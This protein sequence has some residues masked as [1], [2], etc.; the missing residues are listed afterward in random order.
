MCK[1]RSALPIIV[2]LIQTNPA[3]AQKG[4]VGRTF[5]PETKPVDNSEFGFEVTQW[6]QKGSNNHLYF[7]IESFIDA[8][9]FVF[10]SDRSGR[11]NLFKMS[12]LDGTITQMT[13][14][15]GMVQS[16]WHCPQ[17]STVWFV[18]KNELKAV[19]TITLKTCPVYAFEKG[20][21]ASFAVTCDGRYCVFTVNKNPGFSK[22]HSTGPNALFRLD[23]QTKEVRQ[24][25]PD[26][27]VF[28]GHVLANPVDPNIIL[29]VW[30][31][32]MGN[33]EPGIVGDIPAKLWWNNIDG[34]D[35]GQLGTQAFGLHITHPAWFPNGQQI[36]YSARYFFGPN[37]GK[38][39]VGIISSDGKDNLMVQANIGA[40]H[41]QMY[42]DSKHW[43]FDRYNGPYLVMFTMEGKKIAAAETLFRHDSSF[44]G[45]PSHPHPH[46][47]PDGKYVLFSTDRSGRPQVYTVKVNLGQ[48][49]RRA[50]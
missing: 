26:V 6:T 44:K 33:G 5:P 46:F 25:S 35:G 32:V 29:Y 47:S 10:F 9:H 1:L 22:N 3:T 14:E 12:L 11:T 43:V 20:P 15:E 18:A 36:S 8:D 19:N 42:S 39:F 38:Q 7:N 23:L 40:A 49:P 48:P 24:I 28:L 4:S 34:S 21:P 2:M 41:S 17:F 45:Q 16:V 31:P 37:K 27:G 50:Q 30:K 13:D